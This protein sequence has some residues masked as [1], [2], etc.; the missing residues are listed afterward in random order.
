MNPKLV[1]VLVKIKEYF[2]C[3]I[4]GLLNALAMR[5]FTLPNHLVP[6][7]ISGIASLLE[8]IGVLDAKYG[9]FVLNA[10]LLIASLIILKGDFSIKTV[11]CTL[12]G[13]LA[14]NI[15][16]AEWGI[17]GNTPLLLCVIVG[18]IFVG[19]SMALAAEYNGSNAG[20]EILARIVIKYKPEVKLNKVL[21]VFNM[22][23][24]L[25]GGIVLKDFWKLIYSI[26]Y[27]FCGTFSMGIMMNGVDPV[28]KYMIV[29]KKSE[30]ISGQV[31]IK[32][33]RGVSCI[34]VVTPSGEETDNKMLCVLVQYRQAYKL[35]K[36]IKM[37]DKDA[38]VFA[39]EVDDVIT[40][41][42]FKRLYK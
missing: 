28:L 10:P 7:G 22:A 39:K 6:G 5:M 33:K 17:E 11:F 14:L 31:M 15:I 30:E 38:F 36:I 32:F 20:T 13:T 3:G 40:R 19:A 24:M 27:V 8:Y 2:L 16:P 41:P 37:V 29:T 9:Y 26:I 4:A 1:K 23:V 18:G 34:D 25:V 12:V 35:K 42:N 21:L